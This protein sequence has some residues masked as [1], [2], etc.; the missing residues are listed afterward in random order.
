M[1]ADYIQ[2]S[3]LDVGGFQRSVGGDVPPDSLL[4]AS[5]AGCGDTARNAWVQLLRNQTMAD[6]RQ[7]AASWMALVS[8]DSSKCRASSVPLT[9]RSA[10]PCIPKSCKTLWH[11]SSAGLFPEDEMARR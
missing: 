7:E 5:R 8:H 2:A 1:R 9:L 4:G 11:T 10:A 6:V 3:V